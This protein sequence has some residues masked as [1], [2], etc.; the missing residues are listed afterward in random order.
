VNFF[1]FFG[2]RPASL[3]IFERY[4][5]ANLPINAE[6]AAI[7][8]T[9]AVILESPTPLLLLDGELG[10]V[11]ASVSFCDAFGI[12]LATVKGKMLFQLGTGEWDVPALQTL[13]SS[14]T[15]GTPQIASLEIEL[16]RPDF[17]KRCLII[18]ARQLV[19]HD[20][21]HPR[22]LMAVVDV[23]D[24]RANNRAKNS[25]IEHLGVLL[26]EVRHRVANSLQIVATLLLQTSGRTTSVETR[27]HLK[28]AHNRVMSVAALERQLSASPAGDESVELRTYFTNLCN[29]ISSSM[30]GDDKSVALIVTGGGLVT[31][32]VSVSLGLIVTE[33]V[34]NALKHAFPGGRNGR[35]EIGYEAHGPNWTLS[36]RDDGVGMPNDAAVIHT[37]LGTNIVRA[38]AQQLQATVDVAP[39]APGTVVWIEHI[40]V[41]LVSDIEGQAS[42]RAPVKRVG[43]QVTSAE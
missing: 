40:Q 1:P 17:E 12:D 10:V 30:I 25:V 7:S 28:D 41:T 38:L 32:R 39:A 33:L 23:T 26:E 15:S 2:F 36:V 29:S 3:G 42:S 8:L 5:M 6:H 37:G 20:I 4:V 24:A 43:R 16:E 13:F 31:S 18:N 14:V 34:I 11:G 35:I 21:C 27:D 9:M 19:Y 22:L